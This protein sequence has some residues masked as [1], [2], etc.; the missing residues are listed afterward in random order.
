[1][2]F[3]PN[4]VAPNGS[5]LWKPWATGFTG[6]AGTIDIQSNKL[7]MATGAAINSA[8]RL[9][10]DDPYWQ[11][12]DRIEIVCRIATPDTWVTAGF[13]S[14]GIRNSMVTGTTSGLRCFL[15]GAATPNIR[16][17]TMVASVATQNSFANYTLTN[18]V[19][20]WMRLRIADGMT[21][22]KAWNDGTPEPVTW[23]LPPTAWTTWE[24]TAAPFYPNIHQDSQASTTARTFNY[25][26][27]TFD[28]L[29]GDR[30]G[31]LKV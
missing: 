3:R 27:I 28:D 25:D 26:E 10:Y 8:A 21:S 1:M 13:C 24:P 15:R 22:V 2:I 18:G 11:F 31:R 30:G 9:T 16:V 6:T 20:V 12:K 7:H 5:P 4:L 23:I 17:E 14:I 29:R 19:A